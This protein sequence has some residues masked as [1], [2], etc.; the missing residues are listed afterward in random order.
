[1][2]NHIKKSLFVSAGIVAIAGSLFFVNSERVYASVK[3]GQKFIDWGVTCT[4]NGNKKQICFLTQSLTATEKEKTKNLAIFQIGYFGV[5]KERKL[6]MMQIIPADVT[7][8]AG[9][10]II[11]DK[12]LLSPGKYVSCNKEYCQAFAVISE[13]ELATILSNENNVIALINSSRQ[14]VN[15]PVSIKGLAEG[16]KALKE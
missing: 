8:A 16:L 2:L 6:Q 5:G 9:T 11:S 13:K 14:Q 15:I 3:E 7:I 4:E 12:Q 10:S 1:M